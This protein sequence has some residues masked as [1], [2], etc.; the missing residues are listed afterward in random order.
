MDLAKITL[1]I[2]SAL[3]ADNFLTT[4]VSSVEDEARL[5]AKIDAVINLIEWTKTGINLII[6]DGLPW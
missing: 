6:S 2:D 5:N 4:D 1:G 3:I